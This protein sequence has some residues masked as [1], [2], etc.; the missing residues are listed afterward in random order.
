MSNLV[1]IA[2]NIELY[3]K[4]NYLIN[5][6]P[7]SLATRCANIIT[8]AL[9]CKGDN[10]IEEDEEDAMTV[11]LFNILNMNFSHISIELIERTLAKHH[12][13][14]G[15]VANVSSMIECLEKAGLANDNLN[16][17]RQL[18]EEREN[19]RYEQQEKAK[20]KY[21]EEHKEEIEVKYC[22]ECYEDYKRKGDFSDLFDKVFNRLSEKK[23]VF[24]KEQIAKANEVATSQTRKYLTNKR[25][26]EREAKRIN[27]AKRI[28]SIINSTK[29]LQKETYYEHRYKH[30][31]TKQYFKKRYEKEQA[32]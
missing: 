28:G 26:R 6:E 7:K 1:P 2:N 16:N 3:S 18:I 10:K 21:Y 5:V 32:K 12:Y 20:I 14:E 19:E 15:F 31:L 23:V 27:E 22:N 30:E 25:D 13:G 4:N 29:E 8:S 9:I 11:M 24:S 17:K